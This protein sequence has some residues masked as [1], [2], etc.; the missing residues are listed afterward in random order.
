M[1]MIS[2]IRLRSPITTRFSLFMVIIL[3]TTQC[4]NAILNDV[5]FTLSKDGVEKQKLV[6]Q[7][8]A[9]KTSNISN[10]G[11]DLQTL[12]A[13]GE[14]NTDTM[15]IASEAVIDSGIEKGPENKNLDWIWLDFDELNKGLYEDPTHAKKLSNS[16]SE[17]ELTHP[18]QDE[19]LEDPCPSLQAVAMGS[20]CTLHTTDEIWFEDEWRDGEAC[21]EVCNSRV[22]ATGPGCCEARPRDQNYEVID[23]LDLGLAERSFCIFQ[24]NGNLMTGFEDCKATLCTGGDVPCPSLQAVTLGKNRCVDG[25]EQWLED[26]WREGEACREKCNQL[27]KAMGRGCCEA[28]PRDSATKSFCHFYPLIE[29]LT[30]DNPDAKA[31]ICNGCT[32]DG[33]VGNGTTQGNCDDG[34]LC[35]ADGTC[36]D[37]PTTS[38]RKDGPTTSTHEPPKSTIAAETETDTIDTDNPSRVTSITLSVSDSSL[39]EDTTNIDVIESTGQDSF[40]S[41]HVTFVP[42]RIEKYMV[43]KNHVCTANSEQFIKTWNDGTDSEFPLEKIPP[44]TSFDLKECEKTCSDHDECQGFMH[45]PTSNSCKFW[46]RAPIFPQQISHHELTADCYEKYDGSRCSPEYPCSYEHG[47]MCCK[48]GKTALDTPINMTMKSCKNNEYKPCPTS[49]KKFKCKNAKLSAKCENVNG[50]EKDMVTPLARFSL[51]AAALVVCW[52]F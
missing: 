11:P 19:E 21:R 3:L 24:L 12:Q 34:K 10:L 33:H 18:R 30:D 31:T 40:T 14:E 43:T 16:K 17:I 9:T 38:T 13:K 2:S 22:V 41:D 37:G 15:G 20:R 47:N 48:N 23:P 35:D 5:I 27:A 29:T 1:I 42:T 49:S 7:D 50:S 45:I 44:T 51:S 8:V 52:F 4:R 46:V 26:E 28:R 6:A 32:V 36:K 39:V 25:S